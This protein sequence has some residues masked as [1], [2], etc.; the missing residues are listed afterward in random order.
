MLIQQYGELKETFQLIISIKGIAAASAI[1]FLAELM[2]CKARIS[3]W[4]VDKSLFALDTV[5]IAQK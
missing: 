3:P 4:K 2:V 5:V 1:Q